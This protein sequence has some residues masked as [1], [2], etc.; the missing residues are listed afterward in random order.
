[1]DALLTDELF[2]FFEEL[3]AQVA[4]GYFAQQVVL[5]LELFHL[6]IAHPTIFAVREVLHHL[7]PGAQMFLAQR[8]L[9]SACGARVNGDFL[10]TFGNTHWLRTRA[11][12]LVKSPIAAP[13]SFHI[14]RKKL[15]ASAWT[16]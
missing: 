5:L 6:S 9:H 4:H 8:D 15:V 16:L 13:L 12:T 7:V 10:V 1:M 11:T 2:G 3:R 14:W